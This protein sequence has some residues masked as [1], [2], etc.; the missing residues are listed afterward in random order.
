[1]NHIHRLQAELASAR[2]ELRAKR[3]VLHEFHVHLLSPKFQGFDADGQRKDWIATSD[4]IAWLQTIIE[5][6]A[7]DAPDEVGAP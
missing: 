3:N 5:A 6:E 7:P 1:M 2:A 4:V